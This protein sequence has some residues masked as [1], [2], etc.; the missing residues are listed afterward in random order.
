MIN[1]QQEGM[2]Q[3][4]NLKFESEKDSIV[5]STIFALDYWQCICRLALKKTLLRQILLPGTTIY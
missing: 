5:S 4:S 1:C 2:K 3:V